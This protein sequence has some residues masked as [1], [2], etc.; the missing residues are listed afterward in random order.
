MGFYLEGATGL[1]S[2]YGF[3]R[4]TASDGAISAPKNIQIHLPTFVFCLSFDESSLR[5]FQQN[6]CNTGTVFSWEVSIDDIKEKNRS[7]GDGYPYLS[8]RKNFPENMFIG[9]DGPAVAAGRFRA[10]GNGHCGYR[11]TC[12]VQRCRT[13]NC[14]RSTRFHFERTDFHSFL[15]E[16][17]YRCDP[18]WFVHS[19]L[20]R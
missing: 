2:D 11:S 1:N 4:F 18:V 14:N 16:H 20:L 7:W 6:K 3:T 10:G 12:L 9:I 13:R 8:S 15:G 19:D 5:D 17:R